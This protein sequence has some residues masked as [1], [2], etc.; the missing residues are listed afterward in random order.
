MSSSQHCQRR[1]CAAAMDKMADQRSAR[2]EAHAAR[3]GAGT[4]RMRLGSTGNLEGCPSSAAAE[5]AR[6]T[7][8]GERRDEGGVNG[9]RFPFQIFQRGRPLAM[10][11]I[12]RSS[13]CPGSRRRTCCWSVAP[14]SGQT[15]APAR[16][17]AP[18]HGHAATWSPRTSQPRRRRQ[19]AS[20]TGSSIP[21]RRRKCARRGR[22]QAQLQRGKLR[23]HT[24]HMGQLGNQ[25]WWPMLGRAR[26][27]ALC[28]RSRRGHGT[29]I[30]AN[31]D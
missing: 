17:S 4:A 8:M 14:A 20:T 2:V 22:R 24:Q 9:N 6:S 28:H 31:H 19:A 7:S 10:T 11:S 29:K 1:P 12:R 26:V 30:A 16:H 23:K 25:A 13:G 27:G 18:E 5:A 3:E 15:Q 21:S